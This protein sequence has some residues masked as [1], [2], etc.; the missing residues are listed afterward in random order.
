M[1][2]T[3]HSSHDR[4]I[5]RLTP[6]KLIGAMIILV[7]TVALTI[8][9]RTIIPAEDTPRVLKLNDGATAYLFTSMREIILPPVIVVLVTIFSVIAGRVLGSKVNCE[10]HRQAGPVSRAIGRGVVAVLIGMAAILFLVTTLPM[11]FQVR[12]VTVYPNEVVVESLLRSWRMPRRDITRVQL[13]RQDVQWK[14]QTLVGVR[15][16]IEQCDGIQRSTKQWDLKKND[17]LLPRYIWCATELE[18]QL[19]T[20]HGP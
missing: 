1:D 6:Y 15:L 20:V 9:A 19:V 8:V 5:I 14:G 13:S 10:S 17:P 11:F 16:T 3:E 7:P 12:N 4:P 18:N 2:N